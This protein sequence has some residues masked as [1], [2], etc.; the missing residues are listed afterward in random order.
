[1]AEKVCL[2]FIWSHTLEKVFLIKRPNYYCLLSSYFIFGLMFMGSVC[3]KV[4]FKKN[5]KAPITTAADDEFC[6]IFPNF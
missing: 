2:S 5:L 3:E 6:D 1:M 4:K